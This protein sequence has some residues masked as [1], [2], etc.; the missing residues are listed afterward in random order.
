MPSR[1]RRYRGQESI[2]SNAS[3]ITD[4][5]ANIVLLDGRVFLGQIINLVDHKLEYMNTRGAQCQVALNTISEIII[6]YKI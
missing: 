4:K 6:D 3:E 1:L 5:K 2:V